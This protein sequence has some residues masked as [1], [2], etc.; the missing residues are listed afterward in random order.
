MG[1]MRKSPKHKKTKPKTGKVC[2][3]CRFSDKHVH[4]YGRWGC[5][6]EHRGHVGRPGR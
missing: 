1:F 5:E 2:N 3:Q 6:C 4:K